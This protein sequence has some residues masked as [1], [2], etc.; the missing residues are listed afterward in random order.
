M[1]IPVDLETHFKQSIQQ[2]IYNPTEE[3]YPY[4]TPRC[5]S[6]R[7]DWPDFS[8]LGVCALVNDI[9]QS[10]Q[11]EDMDPSIASQ[12]LS[13]VGLAVQ[14]ASLPNGA[15]LLGSNPGYFLNISSPSHHMRRGM[16]P[17]T[18]SF[19]GRS[20]LETA[21]FNFFMIYVNQTEHDNGGK[22]Q[23][24]AVEALLH[25]CVSTYHVQVSD[26]I[27]KTVL[28]KN[29]TEVLDTNG[30]AHVGDQ[31][32]SGQLVLG[33]PYSSQNFSVDPAF[34]I[35]LTEYL[36]STFRGAYSSMPGFGDVMV[37]SASDAIGS[38]MYQDVF[39]NDQDGIAIQGTRLHDV[40]LNNTQ[41]V[42]RSLT[43]AIRNMGSSEVG[44]PYVPETYIQVNWIW[45]AFLAIQV[46]LATLF[47]VVIIVQT[48]R[49]EVPVVKSSVI[50]TLFAMSAD[51]KTLLE[52]SMTSPLGSRRA[53][54][55]AHEE[56]MMTYSQGPDGWSLRLQ[57]GPF[58]RPSHAPWGREVPMYRTEIRHTY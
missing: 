52:R 41:N 13:E 6:S 28:E 39:Q 8:S 47:I 42:A 11:I 46:V 27:D 12:D 25:F 57:D 35:P 49:M 40:I 5:C 20:L 34:V 45:M 54:H 33:N 21:I 9:S 50:A 58:S 53:L 38:A 23:F 4:L 31:P 48:S 44:T 30:T 43:N 2:G 37:T 14:N 24:A 16:R 56:R 36:Q 18:L 19:H 26:G 22:P 15:F 51:D 1:S 29:Y 7:C 3:P 32:V 55:R 10:L 17:S